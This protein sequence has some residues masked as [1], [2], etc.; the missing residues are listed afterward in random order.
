M[1]K[2]VVTRTENASQRQKLN[3]TRELIMIIA[4]TVSNLN[5]PVHRMK[6]VYSQTSMRAYTLE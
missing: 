5:S 3:K 2:I 1:R 6:F 4:P